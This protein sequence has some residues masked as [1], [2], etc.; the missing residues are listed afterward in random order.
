MNGK[1]IKLENLAGEFTVC[2]TAESVTDGIGGKFLFVGKTDNE[3]SVV[4]LTEYAPE[5]TIAREDCWKGFRVCGTLEFS[6]LGILAGISD[7]ASVE[8]E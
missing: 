5:K 3:T 6:L 7:E 2:K 8:R 1:N 4:C